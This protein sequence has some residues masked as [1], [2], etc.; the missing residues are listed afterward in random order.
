[1]KQ[2]QGLYQQTLERIRDRADKLYPDKLL[3]QQAEAAKIMGV[4][5]ETLRRAGLRTRITC[6]QL[7][8][9]FS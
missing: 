1:M 5:V 9:V 7:A 6:E 2:E 8:K 3:Y 4:S